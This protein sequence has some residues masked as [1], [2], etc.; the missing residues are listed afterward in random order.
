LQNL[1]HAGSKQTQSNGGNVSNVNIKRNIKL[2]LNSQ[3]RL[4]VKQHRYSVIGYFDQLSINRKLLYIL[5]QYIKFAG[6]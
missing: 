2:K 5:I 1:T 3:I 6:F 4:P